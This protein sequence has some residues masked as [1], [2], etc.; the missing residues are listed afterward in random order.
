MRG[1]KWELLL[2]FVGPLTGKCAVRPRLWWAMAAFVA[3]VS[4]FV[5]IFRRRFSSGIFLLDFSRR[6]Y[7]FFF[8]GHFSSLFFCVWIFV[9][10]RAEQKDCVCARRLDIET[11]GDVKSESGALFF[12]VLWL[13]EYNHIKMQRCKITPGKKN[14]IIK[15]G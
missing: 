9:V 15:R 7:N 3:A 5:V 6:F 2:L 13:C 4:V 11:R 8:V 1:T 14:K 12:F 10:K